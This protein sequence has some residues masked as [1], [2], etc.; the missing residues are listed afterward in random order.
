MA[1][2]PSMAP[3]WPKRSGGG[4]GVLEQGKVQKTQKKNKEEQ[5]QLKAI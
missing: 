3:P 4:G 1:P 5:G 2:R